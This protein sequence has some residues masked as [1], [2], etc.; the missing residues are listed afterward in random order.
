[1]SW[2]GS[3]HESGLPQIYWFE[4]FGGDEGKSGGEFSNGPGGRVDVGSFR[5]EAGGVWTDG[6]DRLGL[7][8][9]LEGVFFD[10]GVFVLEGIESGVNFTALRI[11]DDFKIAAMAEVGGGEGDCVR[12]T[13]ARSGDLFGEVPAL[14]DRE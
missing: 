2:G 8:Q 6:I 5:A 12:G 3:F 14:S 4:E 10:E 9:D 1:M 7:G 13:D 11:N